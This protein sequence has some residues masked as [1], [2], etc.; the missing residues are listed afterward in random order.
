MY[1]V[2]EITFEMLLFRYLNR[3]FPFSYS[4]VLMSKVK[5]GLKNKMNFK[6]ISIFMNNVEELFIGV[7]SSEYKNN[8]HLHYEINTPLKEG[9]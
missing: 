3:Y 7:F 5:I 1:K 6:K 2:V 8:A 9:K 4:L